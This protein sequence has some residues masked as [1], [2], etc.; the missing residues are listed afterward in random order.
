MKLGRW[1][2]DHGFYF[3]RQVADRWAVFDEVISRVQNQRVLYLEFG[4]DR[5]RTTRYW[6]AIS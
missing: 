5:G 1:M 4:V 3:A 6:S 2:R